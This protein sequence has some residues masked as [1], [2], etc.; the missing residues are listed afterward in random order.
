MPKWLVRW[1]LNIIAIMLT[2]FI[3][4]AFDVKTWWVAIIASIVLA[5]LNAVVRPI[6]MVLTLPINIVTLGLFT[7]VINGFILWLTSKVIDGFVIPGFG[8]AILAALVLSIVSFVINFFIE[9]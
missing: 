6:I 9:D 3:V 5:V 8:T 4:P 2:A 1:G 7:L